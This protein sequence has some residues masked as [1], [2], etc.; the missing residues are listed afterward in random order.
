M[1]T[2]MTQWGIGPVFALA[3][4]TYAVAVG[5]LSHGRAAFEITLVPHSALVA[6]GIV[7]I[8]VG[9][10]MYVL[11]G[12]AVLRAF[13]AGQ[14]VT[15]GV[16][17]ICRHP[18]YGAW[19]VFIVPGIELILGSWLGLTTPLAMYL[20]LRVL[21][22]KEED[23]LAERFGESYAAYRRKVPFIMPIGWLR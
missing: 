17:G 21:A 22:A 5:L 8:A 12:K 2:K 23:Y 3:S 16:Y 7:L 9:V 11:S 18:L 15:D 19:I 10:P 13:H 20:I 6:L 1:T 4:I 14:L